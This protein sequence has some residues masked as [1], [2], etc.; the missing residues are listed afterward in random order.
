MLDFSKVTF[1]N[2]YGPKSQIASIIFIILKIIRL[3]ARLRLRLSQPRK[4]KFK[5]IFQDCL[6]PLRSCRNDIEISSH[7]LL[8]CPTYSNE[9][10]IL[11]KKSKNIDY[12]ISELSDTIMTKTLLLGDNSLS[13]YTMTL[14]LN[15]TV[16]YV[17]AKKR[18]DDLI[19]N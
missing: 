2:S 12:G 7:F 17:I 6:N 3:I 13:D 9:K 10:I 5:H 4:H 15:S 8:H 1:Q 19:V 16:D 11:L 18:F 14:I